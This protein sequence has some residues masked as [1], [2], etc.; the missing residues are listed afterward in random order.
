MENIHCKDKP[1]GYIGDY[2]ASKIPSGLEIHRCSAAVFLMVLVV[3]G[4]RILLIKGY[5]LLRTGRF[6]SGNGFFQLANFS[7]KNRKVNQG[8]RQK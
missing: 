2:K 6:S 3:L 5:A 8:H 1:C 4:L 7:L